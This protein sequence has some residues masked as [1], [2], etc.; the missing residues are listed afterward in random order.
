V[1][2]NS[3]R[4]SLSTTA[5]TRLRV[6]SG[7]IFSPENMTTG[8]AGS[9]TPNFRSQLMSIH[10]RHVVIEKH[11][12]EVKH[13]DQFQSFSRGLC[14]NDDVS[15]SFKQRSL[16]FQDSVTII[17]TEKHSVW[18]LI[19]STHYNLQQG[20]GQPGLWGVHIHPTANNVLDNYIVTSLCTLICAIV[21]TLG[22]GSREAGGPRIPDSSR[23]SNTT[24]WERP[25]MPKWIGLWVNC[26]NIPI[27]QVCAFFSPV[28]RTKGASRSEKLGR[29]GTVSEI[30]ETS[31]CHPAGANPA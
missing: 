2:N 13:R 31:Y 22:L 3:L 16:V 9:D 21:N 25:C 12:V 30:S 20:N 7:I 23:I 10:F 14:G 11:C 28:W 19:L 5:S 27:A 24:A 8:V 4:A 26:R 6:S 18:P 17:D 1:G 29:G 15:R